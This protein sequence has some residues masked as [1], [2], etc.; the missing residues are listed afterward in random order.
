MYFSGLQFK[1]FQD[2]AKK[3]LQYGANVNTTAPIEGPIRPKG[4]KSRCSRELLFSLIKDADPDENLPGN[5]HLVE[6]LAT[7]LV[8]ASGVEILLQHG[9]A[10][11]MTGSDGLTPLMAATSAGHMK[12]MELL[13][14]GGADAS[15]PRDDGGPTALEW[16]C[17]A[18]SYGCS[19][20]YAA[21]HGNIQ[22]V[23]TFL[24]G[25]ARTSVKYARFC[26]DLPLIFCAVD[27][28]HPDIVSLLLE[29][30]E[31]IE[32][33]DAA[34]A[35]P[36]IYAAKMGSPKALDILL[37]RGADVN[38][39]DVNGHSALYWGR[40]FARKRDDGH[41]GGIW[42]RIGTSPWLVT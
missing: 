11:D 35:T 28:D 27:G 6:G 23:R 4:F 40:G 10:V 29:R 42:S 21:E 9:A 39:R 1:G 12:V 38:A 17:D 14:G 36:L 33:R 19:L 22:L 8:V 37:Q 32:C 30:G 16:G 24:D 26:P 3:V 18:G 41:A 13:L 34:A 25:G 7:P 5:F 31:D 15:I 20:T 2:T